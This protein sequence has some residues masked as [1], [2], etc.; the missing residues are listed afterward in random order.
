MYCKLLLTFT[1]GFCSQRLAYTRTAKQV[2]YEALA[3]PVHKVIESWAARR[4][5]LLDQR[6]DQ[7]LG[8]RRQ[9]KVFERFII[10]LKS[11]DIV[12]VELY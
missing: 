9:D 3:F 7:A 8:C 2:D 5:M 10:P 12:D 4:H 1:R 6:L 11:V